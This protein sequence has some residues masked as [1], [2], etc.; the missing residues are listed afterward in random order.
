[1]FESL[2]LFREVLG[3]FFRRDLIVK[4][5]WLGRRRFFRGTFSG[6][7]GWILVCYITWGA[8]DASGRIE[9]MSWRVWKVL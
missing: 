1:M 2:S 5:R 7:S 9:V 6:V 4:E 3:G 8:G